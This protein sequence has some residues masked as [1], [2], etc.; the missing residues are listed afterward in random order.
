[1]AVVLAAHKLPTLGSTHSVNKP[2]PVSPKMIKFLA[3]LC[4]CFCFSQTML[5]WNVEGHMV[6]AQIAYNHLDSTVKAKCDALVAVPLAYG[7]N[8]TS[9]FV[10]AACWAD[11]YKSQLNTGTGHYIDLPFSRYGAQIN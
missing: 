10:T 5:A 9:N 1:M 11:D 8:S 2:S 7:G 3:S 6:V 4:A